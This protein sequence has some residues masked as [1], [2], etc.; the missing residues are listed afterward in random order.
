SGP[1][2]GKSVNRFLKPTIRTS[3]VT[4]PDGSN[5]SFVEPGKKEWAEIEKSTQIDH[6]E[7]DQTTGKWKANEI[8][9]DN[10]IVFCRNVSKK[11]NKLGVPVPGNRTDEEYEVEEV[12]S[13]EFVLIT[14]FLI[15][16]GTAIIITLA[17]LSAYWIHKF[18]TRKPV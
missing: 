3:S 4:C 10:T 8:V 6:L 16:I 15:F 11:E 2:D 5:M 18:F 14:S 13:T 7:C 12:A 1:L 9:P 17:T